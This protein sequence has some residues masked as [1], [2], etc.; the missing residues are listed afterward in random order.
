MRSRIAAEVIVVCTILALPMMAHA[1]EEAVVSGRVTD[2]S[3]GV[4]PGV[5]VRAVHLSTG[6]AFEAVTDELGAYRMPVRVGTVRVTA[7]LQSFNA[8]TREVELLLGQ[9]AVVNLQMS[10]AGVAETLTV[11][12]EAP[13]IETTTSVLGGNVDP[14]QVAE[15]PTYGRN[16]LGLAMVAPGSRLEPVVGSRQES[17]RALPDRNNGETREF[18][19][20]V[21]GQQVTVDLTSQ[22]QPRYSADS[23]SEFQYISNRFDATQG[24]ST[25][26]QVN[27]IT[28]S[29]TNQLA[30]LFRTNFRDSRFNSPNR[31][32]GQVEPID[33]QQFSATLGGPLMRDKLH[34]FGNYEYERE[35]RIGIWRTPY[36]AFN[37]PGLEGTNTQKK[38]GGRLDYQLSSR[39]RLMGKVSAGRYWEPFGPPASGNHPAATAST[40][41]HNDE[42]LGQLT[43]VLSN[44][45]VNEIRVGKATFG[46]TNVNV[47]KWSNHWHKDRGITTGSPRITFTGFLV[48]GNQ[49]FPR[50]N[51]ID[52]W[53]ARDDFTYSFS[54][55]GRHDLR[56]G[57][58]FLYRA[59]FSQNC[60]QCMGLIDAR[61]GPIPANLEALF[62]D[63]FNA[64]TWN[65]AALSP[66]T[67]SYTI[68]TG[69]YNVRQDSQKIAA[70]A[71]DDWQIS[72]R[73]TLNLGVRYDLALGIFANDISFPPFQ[74]AGRPDDY[75]NVQPR[76]GFAYRLS[77]RTVIRGGSGLYYGDSISADQ[78]SSIGNT[79]IAQLRYENDGRPDFTANPTNGRPLPSYDEAIQLNCD[80]NNNAPGCLIRDV[81]E[82]N[83]IPEY[84]QLP[85]TWHTS[86]G[87]QR[88]F[89]DTMSI[90]ADYVYSRGA[91]EKDIIDNINL[92]F[93]P[94]T[95]ANLDFRIRSNRPYPNWGAISMN[96]HTARSAYHGLI[97]GLTKRFANR[98]QA[99]A[100]YTLS[101][102]WAAESRPFSGLD[103]VPFPTA[104]DLGGEW[105]FSESDQRHRAVFSAIWQVGRGFQV[106]GMHYLGAGIRQAHN[107][108]GDLRNTG[109]S[110]S[111]RLRPDGTIT[112]LNDIIAPP[113]NRTDLRLQQRI[114]LPGRVSI[115]GIVEVFN[116]LNRPNWTIGTEE[117]AFAQFLQPINAQYRTTQAGFRVTF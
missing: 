110:F 116:L 52:H 88:Q 3:G 81:R 114:A 74:E 44:R 10:P 102:L 115:D 73:L 24:R 111:G 82:F 94:A 13:L 16:W 63:P 50:R 64:D 85:R 72:D 23:I 31:V 69:N 47:T 49:N 14:R 27:V 22:G 30:G 39:T 46:Y 33:N 83:A 68:S 17:E 91:F 54:A 93:D 9:S 107:Y 86:I 92:L 21:D 77:D 59:S 11:T 35:P 51:D 104:P 28:K 55:K 70:W 36:P 58:E 48:T 5:T 60:R 98:W 8:M 42:Y 57:G 90:E 75:N 4:L 45:A 87:V 100:T 99:S 34:F 25:T 18:Q 71:Q 32:L 7:E 76:F 29:G 117:S 12:G 61:G 109:A 40:E 62:P 26:V 2:S 66:I 108:G 41:E 103:I 53:S 65:L 89:G 37:N 67:R 80:V 15:L 38:G 113:Q 79:Q 97:T 19:F 1:Q 95:G 20:N 101:G 43:Q 112:P 78:S 56:T 106:S 105:G 84:I 6:N 96:T